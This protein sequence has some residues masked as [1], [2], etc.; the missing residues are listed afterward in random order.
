M[1]VGASVDPLDKDQNTPLHLACKTGNHLTVDTLLKYKV[2]KSAPEPRIS[3]DLSPQ[4]SPCLTRLLLSYA[5]GGHH[6]AQ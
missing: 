5:A 1:E 2:G 6:T 4:L 3:V